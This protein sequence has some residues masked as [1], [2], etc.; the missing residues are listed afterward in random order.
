MDLSKCPQITNPSIY[1]LLLNASHLR[2]LKIQHNT[3]ITDEAF[4]TLNELYDLQ[5]HELEREAKT[6]PVYATTASLS[7]REEEERDGPPRMLRPLME[8][9]EM[10]RIVDLTGCAALGDRM[11]HSL[12]ASAPKIRNLTLAKCPEIT[13]AAVD[14]ILKLGKCLHHLHLGHV[15]R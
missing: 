14:S 3:N 11:V 13:D 12:V 6:A 8:K 4:P 1:A 7:E 2:D 10:L 9:L 15:A 5:D